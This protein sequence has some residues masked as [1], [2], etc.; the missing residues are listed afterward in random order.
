MR[1]GTNL[2]MTMAHRSAIVYN[3]WR[4]E[5]TV[6]MWHAQTNTQHMTPFG[7][8]FTIHTFSSFMVFFL[9]CCSSEFFVWRGLF[10][11]K[12]FASSSIESVC[13]CLGGGLWGVQNMIAYG[14]ISFRCRDTNTQSER[15]I[16]DATD[17]RR[18][19]SVFTCVSIQISNL[20]EKRKKWQF[21]VRHYEDRKRCQFYNAVE[22]LSIA[23]SLSSVSIEISSEQN[24]SLKSEICIGLLVQPGC[25]SYS[26]LFLYTDCE[27][28]ASHPI[29]RLGWYDSEFDSS[30]SRASYIWS[31][32]L[33]SL[34]RVQCWVVEVS[35]LNVMTS[36]AAM[37]TQLNLK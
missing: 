25:L 5:T 13:M 28:I 4:K 20:F 23:C 26:H 37:I 29:V 17:D 9:F 16:V 1:R 32:V 10:C 3:T 31:K 12:N 27:M 34:S 2:S 36:C 22:L 6:W 33:I 14:C 35:R 15:W 8:T 11:V 7:I 24:L 21:N 30:V 18:C 19:P